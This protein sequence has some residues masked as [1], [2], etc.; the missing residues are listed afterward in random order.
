MKEEKD[1]KVGWRRERGGGEERC[2][3]KGIREGKKEAEEQ[4]HS[5][6][7]TLQTDGR[8]DRRFFLSETFQVF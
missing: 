3:R 2:E 5:S 4:Q 6:A 1:K 8:T 7:G